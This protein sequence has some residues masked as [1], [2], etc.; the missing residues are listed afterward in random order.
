MSDKKRREV[1][2]NIHALAQQYEDEHGKAKPDV[3]SFDDSGKPIV[4]VATQRFDATGKPSVAPTG[5]SG[6]DVQYGPDKGHT[7]LAYQRFLNE[8]KDDTL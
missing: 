8:E 2:A 5:P 3:Q 4:H 1:L 6:V 7:A